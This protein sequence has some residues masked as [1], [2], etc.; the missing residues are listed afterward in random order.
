MKIAYLSSG[1][2]VNLEFDTK[3]E[4]DRERAILEHPDVE[5]YTLDDFVIA[6]NGDYIS[7]LGYIA[8]I[9]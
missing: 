6:F 9:E 7:D 2:S 3:K 4:G 1:L 5:F 8:L